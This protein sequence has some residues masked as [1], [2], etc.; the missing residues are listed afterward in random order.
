MSVLKSRSWEKSEPGSNQYCDM[1]DMV[2]G[3]L[4]EDGD[5]SEFTNSS[6]RMK[7]FVE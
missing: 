7:K 3:I 2:F 1:K 6:R 4:D 5:Y